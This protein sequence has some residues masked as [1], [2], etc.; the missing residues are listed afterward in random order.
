MI[1]KTFAALE[2]EL[3]SCFLERAE[4]IRGLLV[5]AIARGNILILGAPGGAK[6]AIAECLAQQLGGVFFSRLLT[7]VS[8][9]EELFG[10]L[11]LKA[12]ENDQYKR[13]TA[14]KLPEADIAVIDEVFKCNSAVLNTLLPIMN[15]RVYFDDGSTPRQIPLQ[16]LVGLSN[17][18]PDGGTDGELAALWDRFDLRY[19]VEYI[20]DERNF[21]GMLQLSSAKPR[22]TISL[23]ELTTVQKQAEQVKITGDIIQALVR[24]WKELRAQ[25]FI[26][27][28]RRFR[29]C[30]RFLQAHAWLEGRLEVADDDIVILSHMLW[31]EPE[32]IKAIRKMVLGFANPLVV[33]ANEIFD[34]ALEWKAK[35]T[36][37]PDGAERTALATEANHKLKAAQRMLTELIKQAKAEGKSSVTITERLAAIQAMNE[38]VVN[39]YLLGL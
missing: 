29:N 30:L 22:T 2:Q 17:E 12:L 27:S 10:P 19:T 15:E 11:S 4:V 28:D 20:K 13:V 31:T 6:T 34:G 39:T 32:Q 26:I 16:V 7:K 33:K 25:G 35:L 8:T 14:R 1:N 37:T 9:P 23:Q 21:A 18:L 36:A 38:A 24:L 5:A 3:N